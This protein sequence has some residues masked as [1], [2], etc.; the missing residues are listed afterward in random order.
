LAA[1][2]RAGIDRVQPGIESLSTSILQLMRKGCTALQNLQTLKWASEF[3]I[4]M[5]WN[6][7]MGFPGEDPRDYDRIAEMVPSLVHLPPPRHLGFIRLDR[8]SPYFTAPDHM[9]MVRVRPA[10]PYLDIYPFPEESVRRLAYFFHYDY[11]DGRDPRQY[12]EPAVRMMRFW[13]QNYCAYSFVSLASGDTLILRDRRPGVT[14]TR[15]RL[16]G[17]QRA[18]YEF[19]DSAHPVPAIQAH[20]RNLGYEVRE[21][22]LRAE[23]E[24]WRQKRWIVGD[25]DSYLAV[26]VPMDHM[27]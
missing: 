12:V 27:Y 20:V 17:L 15:A 21:D 1:L 16:I 23:L 13:Q 14:E 24:D 26:A 8:F 11:A 4:Q 7:L 19:L 3:Q 6:F 2:K 9:G 25:R 10:K 18:A 5:F 22:V